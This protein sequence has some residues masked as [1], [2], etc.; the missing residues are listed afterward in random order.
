[1]SREVELGAISLLLKLAFRRVSILIR[2]SLLEGRGIIR[3][4][5]S[6]SCLGNLELTVK[7]E[8]VSIRMGIYLRVGFPLGICI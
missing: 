1:V 7:V 4:C 5:F 8:L 6:C 3:E 2:R